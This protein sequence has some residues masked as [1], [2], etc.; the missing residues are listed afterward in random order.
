MD[1]LLGAINGGSIEAFLTLT[2]RSTDRM[3]RTIHLLQEVQA[4][5]G[6][7]ALRVALVG[8]LPVMDGRS[9]ES[10][11]TGQGFHSLNPMLGV[12][13]IESKMWVINDMIPSNARLCALVMFSLLE[14]FLGSFTDVTRI[15]AKTTQCTVTGSPKCSGLGL[16]LSSI[17]GTDAL[18]CGAAAG[19]SVVKT[20][21]VGGARFERKFT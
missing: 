7:F 3:E 4:R 20:A 17:G 14:Y 15:A 19:R 6:G 5:K 11:R 9:L 8:L 18:P 21:Q 2:L 13:L 1:A 16:S 10:R 12:H